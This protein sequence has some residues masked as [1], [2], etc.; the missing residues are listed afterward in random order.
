MAERRRRTLALEL[1]QMLVERALIDPDILAWELLVSREMLDAWL[2]DAVSIPPSRQLLL[3]A[4]VIDRVRPLAR[5]GYRLRGH[6]RAT[7]A[8]RARVTKT[9]LTAPVS[10]FGPPARCTGPVVGR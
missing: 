5:L 2:T 10:R 7:L 3:A 9:H 4:L 6:V 8:F 1:L